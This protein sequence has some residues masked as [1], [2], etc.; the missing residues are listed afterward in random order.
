MSKKKKSRNKNTAIGGN[1]SATATGNQPPGTEEEPLDGKLVVVVT[2]GDR[3]N[4]VM[5]DSQIRPMDVVRVWGDETNMVNG[6]VMIDGESDREN[7]PHINPEY[8]APVATQSHAPHVT[9]PICAIWMTSVHYDEALAPG[10]WHLSGDQKQDEEEETPGT[11][12]LN[13]ENTKNES[14]EAS[15]EEETEEDDKTEDETENPPEGE[16]AEGQGT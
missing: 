12:Q 3:V 5:K 2:V 16:E 13:S 11:I 10:T 1:E 15:K 7:I 14:A 4:F 8:Q 9:Y 6:V